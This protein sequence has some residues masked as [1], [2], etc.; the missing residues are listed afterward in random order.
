MKKSYNVWHNLL[1]YSF[2]VVY[3]II[4]FTILFRTSHPSRS[5]N[6]IPLRSIGF[7]LSGIDLQPYSEREIIILSFGFTNLVGNIVLFIPLGVYFALF[8]ES[9]GIRKNVLAVCFISM[10]AEIVQYILKMGIADVDDVILNTLGG[11]IGV[12]AYQALM[13][14][15]KSREKVRCVI[16]ILAPIVGIIAFLVVLLFRQ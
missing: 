10:A 12:I 9:Y 3:I 2:F 8:H 13:I 6:F 5:I 11:F 16:E 4:L 15:L 14:K 7:Y 1:L